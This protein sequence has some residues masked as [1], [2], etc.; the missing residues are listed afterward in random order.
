MRAHGSST[1]RRFLAGALTTGGA[2]MLPRSTPA[3]E[4][5]ALVAI[6]F[7]LEMSRHYP[8]WDQTHWDYEK[9]NLDGDTKRYCLEAAR[10]VRARGGRIHF[11]AVGQTLEQ[12]NIE[13]LREL[14]AEG[15]PV[16]SHTY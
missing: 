9:G 15:H 2:V 5:K 4:G 10:R 6:T 12:D 3:D 13:W 14:I 16:G 1:R 8:T 7:D 11:F